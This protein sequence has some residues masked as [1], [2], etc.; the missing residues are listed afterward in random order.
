MGTFFCSL[1]VI[2][3]QKTNTQKMTGRRY[4]VCFA[5]LIFINLTDLAK[6]YLTGKKSS[7]SQLEMFLSC[8]TCSNSAALCCATCLYSPSLSIMSCSFW[9]KQA[10]CAHSTLCGGKQ[11]RR[12]TLPLLC[13]RTQNLCQQGKLT[14]AAMI[15]VISVYRFRFSEASSYKESLTMLSFL[16]RTLI[17]SFSTNII[18]RSFLF[19]VDSHLY[20]RVCLLIKSFATNTTVKLFLCVDPHVWLH[21]WL[22]VKS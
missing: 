17:K 18:N 13:D 22:L 5:P 7:L 19:C 9:L 8:P 2:P 1:W 20:A 3:T 14:T 6:I 16:H 10:V 21:M 11:K 12:T 15:P 4:Q